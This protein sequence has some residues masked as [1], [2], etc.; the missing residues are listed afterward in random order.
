MTTLKTTNY[1]I[2][3]IDIFF[4]PTEGHASLLLGTPE[5]S[6]FRHAKRNIGNV[7]SAEFNPDVTYVDHFISVEGARRRDL[8]QPTTKSLTINFTFDEINATNMKRFFLASA[9]GGSAKLLAPMEKALPT[10]SVSVRFITDVGRDFAYNIP[11][12]IIRPD[13]ALAMNTEDW[14]TG[15][16]VLDILYYATS[17]W[18]SKPYGKIDM[19]AVA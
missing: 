19:S 10:G 1:T 9:L 18:A 17:H 5:G 15:P 16:M 11:K 3:G 7:V 12:A 13:G 14:W 8:I 2:G 4:D 6:V